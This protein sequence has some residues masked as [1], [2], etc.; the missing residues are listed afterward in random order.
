MDLAGAARTEG[1]HCQAVFYKN[2]IFTT[3][4]VSTISTSFKTQE[5]V[6]KQPEVY[7]QRDVAQA[8]DLQESWAGVSNHGVSAHLHTFRQ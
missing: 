5:S 4:I 7:V 3:D 6:V 2:V 8:I 1:R